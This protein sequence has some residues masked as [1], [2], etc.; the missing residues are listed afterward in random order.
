MTGEGQEPRL[1]AVDIRPETV[2][3]QLRALVIEGEPVVALEIENE[4]HDCGV[5]AVEIYASVAAAARALDAGGAGAGR[6]DLAV[7][8]ARLAEEN[9]IAFCERLA[10]D[11]VPLVVTTA[12]SAAAAY[13]PAAKIVAALDRVHR[14]AADQDFEGCWPACASRSAAAQ[15]SRG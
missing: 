2:M 12:D 1:E 6:F 11:G 5:A 15:E 14:H 13:F 7:V 9:V 10:A 3:K 8:E 4:L